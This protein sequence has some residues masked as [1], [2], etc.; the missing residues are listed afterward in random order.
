M[1]PAS[2]LLRQGGRKHLVEHRLIRRP[3]DARRERPHPARRVRVVVAPAFGEAE[4]LEGA[5]GEAESVGRVC[6]TYWDFRQKTAGFTLLNHP[7]VG[8]G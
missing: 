6:N 4:A 5:G 7:A 8:S 2:S 1:R 3:D